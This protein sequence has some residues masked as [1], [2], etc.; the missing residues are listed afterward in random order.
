MLTRDSYTL[1]KRISSGDSLALIDLGDGYDGFIVSST[2]SQV[3]AYLAY[4]DTGH[5]EGT[6][7]T[8]VVFKALAAGTYHL[9]VK[10]FKCSATADAQKIVVFQ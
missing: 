10:K 6:Q 2:T 1:A 8:C 7:G 4:D 9:V 5:G 3:S